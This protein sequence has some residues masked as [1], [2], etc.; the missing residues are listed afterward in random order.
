[1]CGQDGVTTN[2]YEILVGKHIGK[3]SLW[4][5]RRWEFNI[6]ISARKTLWGTEKNETDLMVGFVISSAE[7]SDSITNVKSTFISNIFLHNVCLAIIIYVSRVILFCFQHS[8]SSYMKGITVH[9]G[10]ECKWKEMNS[11]PLNCFNNLM[12]TLVL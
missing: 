6:K 7:P 9:C 12:K 10:T 8:Y 1:M 5:P 4:R 2:A 11:V 3:F